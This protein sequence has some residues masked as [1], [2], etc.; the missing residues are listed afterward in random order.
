[1]TLSSHSRNP[2]PPQPFTPHPKPSIINLA[3][4]ILHP[5]PSNRKS[6]PQPQAFQEERRTPSP[7]PSPPTPHGVRNIGHVHFCVN[8]SEYLAKR[9]V[10]GLVSVLNVLKHHDILVTR[11]RRFKKR[12]ARPRPPPPRRRSA[13]PSP[14]PRRCGPRRTPSSH[15]YV[16]GCR[17]QGAGCWA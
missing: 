14:A 6:P 2:T 4:Y 7:P 13:P 8:R 12:D 15:R 3:P 1:M 11:N 9:C 5:H 10:F 16:W 17:V